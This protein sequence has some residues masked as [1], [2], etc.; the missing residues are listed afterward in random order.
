MFLRLLTGHANIG[1]KSTQV[2]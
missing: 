1:N 2:N